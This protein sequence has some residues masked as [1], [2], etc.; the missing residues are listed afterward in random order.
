MAVAMAIATPM[1]SSTFE[2]KITQPTDFEVSNTINSA[3]CP[4]I[5]LCGWTLGGA[6]STTQT[7]TPTIQTNYGLRLRAT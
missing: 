5:V 6:S 1:Y 2:C 4:T 3:I 7:N